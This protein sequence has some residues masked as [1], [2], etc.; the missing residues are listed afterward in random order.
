MEFPATP[1]VVKMVSPWG[2]GGGRVVVEMGS[3][4]EGLVVTVE[5]LVERFVAAA[6]K[7]LGWWML[8]EVGSLVKRA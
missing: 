6:V 4:V 1:E 8:V 2:G 7:F 3:L 5:S